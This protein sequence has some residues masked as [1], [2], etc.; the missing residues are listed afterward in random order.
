MFN[1]VYS[2]HS[3]ISQMSKRH[4]IFLGWKQVNL[5]LTCI[6][7]LHKYTWMCKVTDSLWPFVVQISVFPSS[8][9]GYPAW[10]VSFWIGRFSITKKTN[11]PL[12]A[13]LVHRFLLHIGKISIFV[14]SNYKNFFVSSL[15]NLS[16]KRQLNF[17]K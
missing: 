9:E 5:H 17:T 11:D 13:L 4:L 12:H 8:E 15:S 16:F 3:D 10:Q 1:L 6:H 7:R 14:S 2:G